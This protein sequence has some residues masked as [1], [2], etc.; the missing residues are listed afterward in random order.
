MAS[1]ARKAYRIKSCMLSSLAWKNWIIWFFFSD[2]LHTVITSGSRLGPCQSPSHTCEGWQSHWTRSLLRER[3]FVMGRQHWRSCGLGTIQ[4]LSYFLGIERNQN[5]D[6]LQWPAEV[7]AR[8]ALA[9]SWE[10]G[11][12]LRLKAFAVEQLMSIGI[13]ECLALQRADVGK[14]MMNMAN[15][16]LLVLHIK[17]G[18][19]FPLLDVRHIWNI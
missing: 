9:A 16:K 4:R 3:E 6:S 12:T 15:V 10:D 7:M 17:W 13:L 19:G 2:Y 18:S 1:G 11:W 5:V 8:G 14:S